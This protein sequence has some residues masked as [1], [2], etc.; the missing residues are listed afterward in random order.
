MESTLYKHYCRPDLAAF[1]E[2]I[3][4][5]V[6]FH[7]AEGSYVYYYKDGREVEVLDLLGGYGTLLLGHNHPEIVSFAKGLL[8]NKTPIH[9]Q[10]SVRSHAARLAQRLSE[11][12]AP[13][14]P[15]SFVVTF[16]N[17]GA[18]AIEAAIKHAELE[19]ALEIRRIA[20]DIE[21]HFIAIE[22]KLKKNECYLGRD[23]LEGTP[24]SQSGF[25][26]RS[27]DE[28]RDRIL[29]H[30]S[31]V[32]RAS[33]VF[34]AVEG[35]FHGKTTG[36]VHLT[37]KLEYREP[38]QRIGLKT[39][40]LKRGDADDVR[41]AIEDHTSSY[42]DVEVGER[43][44]LRVR[45]RPFTNISAC[46]VEPVQGEGG[47][48]PLPRRYLQALSDRCKEARIPV[49]FD[50]IQSGMGRCGRFLYSQKLGVEADYY[51]LSKG[52]GGG[53]AKIAALLVARSRYK[54]EFSLIHT[55]TFAEDEFSSAVASKTLE[56]LARDDW[57]IL[58]ECERKGRYLLKGLRRLRERY[59]D[60][61]ED[62]RGA[63]LLIGIE[64]RDQYHSPS[65][66]LRQLSNQADLV[67]CIAGYLFHEHRIRVAPTLNHSSTLRVEPP[68]SITKAEMD[69]CIR[70]IELAAE[71]IHKADTY[72]LCKYI[73]GLEEPD[74]VPRILDYRSRPRTEDVSDGRTHRV[75]FLGHFIEASH[76]AEHEEPFKRMPPRKYEEFLR[77]I[78][79]RTSPFVVSRV[80]VRSRLGDVVNFNFIGIAMTSAR[81]VELMRAGDLEVP[82]RLVAEAVALAKRC[83]AI[84]LGLGQYTSIITRNCTDLVE[85]EIALTSGNALTVAMG[86]EGILKA[87]RE[88]KVSLGSATVGVVGAGGNICSV[89]ASLMAEKAER[90]VLFGSSRAG[91]EERC[92]RTAFR[93]YGDLLEQIRLRE[94]HELEGIAAHIFRYRSVQRALSRAGEQGREEAGKEVFFGL[95]AE[96]GTDRFIRISGNLEEI[97]QFPL[98][99]TAANEARPFIQPGHLRKD[100][101]VCD[102]AVPMNTTPQ[103][104]LERP[105][106]LVI[107]GGI[108]KLPFGEDLRIRALPLKA[109][110]AFACMAETMLLGLTRIGFHYSF[111]DIHKE[112]VEKIAE[113][114][115]IHGFALA[116]YRT[117]R[118]F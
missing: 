26:V 48:F 104:F 39:V 106:V 18:E 13:G 75:A 30:N 36:A 76:L 54:P 87:A 112:Q 107:Q 65:N 110:T 55:S 40:F 4:L 118:S 1:L 2:A 27:L 113:I 45:E 34:L 21:E 117:Q 84:A 44:A 28:L 72:H 92:L 12:V 3:R 77:R 10:G 89:Y 103:V 16:A 56:I 47:V 20:K 58:G 116:D 41:R 38:F 105:D 25:V 52:L 23:A 83:G 71:S 50:E 8:E 81:M 22:K 15:D 11:C 5:D 73:A 95:R 82:K 115:R 61:I 88:K 78:E 6:N 108:V 80:D 99:V 57:A 94:R 96:L 24:L 60:V 67:Y 79:P 90:L 46:F 49:V 9:V 86:V 14:R 42:Y 102:I 100:A 97:R 59:P 91:G 53:I 33:P 62:V 101:V 17:S 31:R 111:G 70:A 51:T 109:G 37:A 32:F 68:A 85:N 93:I 43:G 114:A 64:F 74:S 7:R 19:K 98:V 66:I 69:R 35:A 29:E 63:G